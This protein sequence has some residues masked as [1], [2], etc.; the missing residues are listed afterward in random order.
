MKKFV[1]TYEQIRREGMLEGKAEGK[2]EGMAAS[3]LRVLARR[4]GV[5]PEAHATRVRTAALADLERW[6]DRVLDAPSIDALL[7]S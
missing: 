1:S 7:D 6:T 4:F 5:V 3:L 2:A